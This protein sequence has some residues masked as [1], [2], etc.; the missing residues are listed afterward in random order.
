[1]KKHSK[2]PAEIAEKVSR[3]VGIDLG[4]KKSRAC[5]MDEQGQVVIQEWV[6]TTPEA[7]FKRFHGQAKMRIAMEVGT[8]S[9]W[10]SEVLK[11]CGHEVLVADARQLAVITKSN[12]KSDQ[13]DARMLAQLVRADPR[14][15]SPIEHRSEELQRDLTLIH[16][17]DNLVETRTRLITSV[18]GVVKASGAR[19]PQCPTGNFPQQVAEAIPEP[20]RAALAP[21]LEIIDQVNEQ[22]YACDGTLEHWA[23]TRYPESARLSQVNG[24]G[25]LTALAFLLTVGDKERFSRS[26]DI[27]SFLGLRPRLEQ[28]GDRD[29]ELRITKAGDGY[30]RKTLVECAQHIVGPFGQD[31]DLRRWGLKVM[32]NGNGSK[33]AKQRAVVGVAR[34][35]AV[36]LMSLWKSGETYDPLRHSRSVEQS[37]GVAA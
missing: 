7:F 30:L 28:S 29:P 26:R 22:I 11:R 35:L 23:Q 36:L 12:A 24:V 27:G 3:Y 32:A 14:L 37:E 5:T 25:T 18:R 10:A 15:L 16:Q 33:R 9:R 6:A 4:D 2:K 21:T 8:H 34:R 1:M 13:R 19:L 31:S 17:R 20:L